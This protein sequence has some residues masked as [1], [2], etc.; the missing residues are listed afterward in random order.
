MGGGTTGRQ[1]DIYE[2]NGHGIKDENIDQNFG[3]VV[4]PGAWIG[5]SYK[6][7][8]YKFVDSLFLAIDE[9]VETTADQMRVFWQLS[10]IQKQLDNATLGEENSPTSIDFKTYLRRYTDA[11]TTGK[12]FSENFRAGDY[13]IIRSQRGTVEAPVYYY[14]LIYILQLYDDSGAFD[15]NGRLD[16]EKTADLFMKPVYLNI[17]T[18]CEL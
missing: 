12:N 7:D 16:Q 14:G 3:F 18:Q 4:I 6:P 1:C 9:T 8:V 13:L 11:G 2:V 17:K 15:E 10:Q 5:E